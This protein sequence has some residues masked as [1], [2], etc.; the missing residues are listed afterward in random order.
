MVSALYHR[1][2]SA[3][4]THRPHSRHTPFSSATVSWHLL[5]ASPRHRGDSTPENLHNSIFLAKANNSHTKAQKPS[6]VVEKKNSARHYLLLTHLTC[7]GHSQIRR[8]DTTSPKTK[9]DPYSTSAVTPYG[10]P[11]LGKEHRPSLILPILTCNGFR[12]FV[13]RSFSPLSPFPLL[14]PRPALP[15]SAPIHHYFHLP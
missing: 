2:H 6:T 12:S 3:P 11:A 9:L 7:D 13:N 10:Q 5:P 14:P 8:P 1:N 15:P 4:P